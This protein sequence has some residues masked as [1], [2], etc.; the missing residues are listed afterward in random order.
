[1]FVRVKKIGPCEYLYL[2]ES[3]REGGRHAQRV[4]KAL[5][6]GS[7]R[8]RTIPSTMRTGTAVSVP[9]PASWF[10]HIAFCTAKCSVARTPHF[11]AAILKA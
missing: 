11:D 4:I 7:A 6:R 9:R 8:R 10:P 3:V 5:P 2:V 1:M